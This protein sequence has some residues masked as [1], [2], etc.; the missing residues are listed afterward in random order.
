M[1][2]PF[3]EF[4]PTKL[5]TKTGLLNCLSSGFVLVHWICFVSCL[6]FTVSLDNISPLELQI[7]SRSEMNQDFIK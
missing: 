2:N 4:V 3:M 1:Q 6:F 7:D 5:R